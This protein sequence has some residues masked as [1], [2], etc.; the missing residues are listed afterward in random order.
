MN[1]IRKYVFFPPLILI[2]CTILFSQINNKLFSFYISKINEWILEYF[3]FV[4][5]WSSFIFIILLVITYFSPIAKLKIGGKDAIPFLSKTRWFAI[6]VC[7]TIATGIL[8]WGCAEPLYH[9]SSPSI[10]TINPLSKESISFSISTMFMHWSFTPYAIYCLAG[11]VFALS[12]YNLKQKFSVSSL[13]MLKQQDN[14]K[15]VNTIV[16]VVC[17]YSLVLGM[18]A[19]LGAGIL[20]IIGGVEKIF[21]I[22][23]SNFLIGLVGLIIIASFITS[24]ISGLQKGIKWLSSINI[25]GFILLAC[26]IFIFSY[27]IEITQIAFEGTKEYVST[28]LQRSINLNSGINQEWRNDWTIFYLANWF[29]WAP[30]ASLFLGRISRG[31]TVRQY[32]NFNWIFPSLFAIVDVYF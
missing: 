7:T 16:D 26:F 18:S 14:K 17:L 22:P 30:V 27:P 9:Y 3:G 13:F 8:F 29:A 32:I 4:F 6:S 23:K 10:S 19:S 2:V 11:L 25:F 24:A 5:S 1:N 20:S 28:F 21:D 31:Y 15:I 12:Y